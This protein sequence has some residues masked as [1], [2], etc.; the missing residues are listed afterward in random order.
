LGKNPGGAL[1]VLNDGVF[2]TGN[3]AP[4]GATGGLDFKKMLPLILIGGYFL[5]KKKK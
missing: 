2:G 4:T 5:L 3:S 1:G